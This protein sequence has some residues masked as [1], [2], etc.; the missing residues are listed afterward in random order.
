VLHTLT[1]ALAKVYGL[2]GPTGEPERPTKPENVNPK[3]D[4]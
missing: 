3:T 1:R 4:T 2:P